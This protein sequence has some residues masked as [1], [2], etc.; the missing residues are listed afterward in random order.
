MNK[1]NSVS[2]PTILWGEIKDHKV[3]SIDGKDMGKIKVISQNHFM[4]EKGLTK[5]TK[6][7]IPKFLAD[8]YD[9]Q[10]LW[11]NV[12]KKDII[13]AFYYDEEPEKLRHQKDLSSFNTKYGFNKTIDSDEKIPIAI[14]KDSSVT[15]QRASK[16]PYKNIRDLK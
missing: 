2:G 6:F 12:E 7:W 5:K 16:Q 8:V 14:N 9:G 10:C 15:Q 4:V 13:D 3:K 11:L 1:D